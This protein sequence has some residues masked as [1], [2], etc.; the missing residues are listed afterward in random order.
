MIAQSFRYWIADLIAG[1]ALTDAD[2]YKQRYDRMYELAM[3]ASFKRDEVNEKAATY[4]AAL[5]TIA[6][7][8]TPNAAPSAKRMAS[9][10]REAVKP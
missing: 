9:V 5:R 10:A 6:A 1:G 8:E 7:M 4:R 2:C 3:D